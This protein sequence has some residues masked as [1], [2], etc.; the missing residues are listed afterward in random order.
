MSVSIQQRR[1]AFR[2]LHEQGCFV[3]P[4]PWDV[5]TAIYLQRLGF[6]AL[7]STSA[8]F[9]WTLGLADGR[10]PRAAVLEHLRNLVQGTTLPINADFESGFGADPEGVAQSVR[11]AVDTGIAGLSIEDSSGDPKTPIRDL[12]RAVARLKA[13]RQAIDDTGKDVL[14]I[15]R[16]ENYLHGRRDLEDTLTRLKAYAEARADCL[17][18][19]GISTREEITAVVQAVA[20]KPVNVLVG[21]TTEFTVKDLADM[22]VRRISIGGA[23]ARTAWAGLEQAAKPLLEDG[24]FD[25]LGSAMPHAALNSTF[26]RSKLP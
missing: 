19:P 24:S 13:A 6:Q 10:V 16:A 2:A 23:L 4:N 5:G 12:D 26:S 15:G 8:G 22:G 20:P 7:A 1:A 14:L 25:G 11:L 18:A 17:Y 9:A 3:L 21:R